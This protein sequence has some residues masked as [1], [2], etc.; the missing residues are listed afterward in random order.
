MKLNFYFRSLLFLMLCILSAEGI[1]QKQGQEK[2]DSLFIVLKKANE[3][4]NKVKILN[5]LAEKLSTNKPDTSILLCKEAI[6]LSEKLHWLLGVGKSNHY[7]GW[8][9]YIKA[10][11]MKALDCDLK[12]IDIFEKLE[13][14]SPQISR[15]YILACKSATLGNMGVVYDDKGDYLKALDYYFYS[16]K[17][18]QQ[19]GDKDREQTQYGNIGMIYKRQG[20]CSKALDYYFKA[21]RI[22]EDL[23]NKKAI[24]INLNNI[25]NIYLQYRENTSISDN[26]FRDSLSTKALDY[27]GKALKIAKEIGNNF[28]VA[29]ILDNLGLVNMTQGNFQKAIDFFFQ[30]L[31]IHDQ[32]GNK[33]GIARGLDHIGIV[34]YQQ[35]KEDSALVYFTQALKIAREIKSKSEITSKLN[36][37]GAIYLNQK[38]YLEAKKFI[39]EA[40][41]LSSEIGKKEGLKES[42][43]NLSK[44]DSAQGDFKNAFENYKLYKVF[45]DS[46]S[47]DE[48]TQEITRKE[49][50]FKFDKREATALAAQDKK[51]AIAKQEAQKQKVIR[52]SVIGILLSSLL[53]FFFYKRKRDAEQ[54]QKETSLSLQVSETEMKAL[55]SQ[56]NPHFIFNALQS[57]QTFLLSHKSD[58]A[59][60]YLLKFSKLMRLVLENSQHSEVSLKEDLEALELYMQLECIRL[61]HPFTYQFHVDESVDVDNTVIPPLIL[62]PFVENAIWH[63]LQYK[64][65]PGH[66]NIYIRKKDNALYATVEDNGVGR[67]MSKQVAQPMLLKKESLG[68]KLTEERLKILNEL[69]KIKAEFKITDLFTNESKPV[70]TRVELS[71]PL[72]T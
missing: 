50:Q 54:K 48:K 51:D 5:A 33:N 21:L 14:E 71:L 68:M 2:I 63:G 20:D 29:L 72:V 41:Q 11:Y 67:D 52:N 15:D 19:I 23:A 9:Y 53:S 43:F 13:K 1:A 24:A 40:L 27:Y 34:Y 32:L 28:G 61:P 66:I 57:I 60:T 38:N 39:E 8:A 46:M 16:L 45:L 59:N 70:G 62:Q 56:M 37:I 36:H 25:G 31:N 58:D 64:P 30:A 12:A 7:L 55:R 42:Y 26:N 22:A 47:N 35:N 49:M 65:E 3:D 44:L 18:A 6:E 17:V 4:T 10:D 69:K